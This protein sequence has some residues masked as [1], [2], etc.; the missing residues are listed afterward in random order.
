[1]ARISTRDLVDKIYMLCEAYSGMKLF[2][3]QVQL[4]KRYIRSVITNDGDEITGLQSRQS[5]KS[6]VISTTTGGLGIFLPVLANLPMFAGDKR[7]EP[8]KNGLLVGIFAPALH[9]S[10]IT[11]NRIKER[12]GSKAAIEVL[13]DPQINV[14]FSTN[15]G[16]NIVLTNG[17]VITSMSASEGSNIEGKSYHI[18]I[19]DEAQDVGDFKYSKSIR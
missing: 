2:P 12:M 7:L 5:G 10:Q 17:T 8:F 9:Q 14:G 1:M 16:Q 19:V 11:F 6:E 15:N 4:S 3:Y 18:I 13:N